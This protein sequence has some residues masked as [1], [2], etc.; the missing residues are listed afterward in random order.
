MKSSVYLH[1]RNFCRN[2]FRINLLGIYP[3]NLIKT[4]LKQR[5]LSSL[6]TKGSGWAVHI[7][8][9]TSAV[10]LHEVPSQK[11]LWSPAVKAYTNLLFFQYSHI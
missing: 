8:V 6:A 5:V 7:N 2:L 10:L 11:A 3:K 4:K 9:E 1:W